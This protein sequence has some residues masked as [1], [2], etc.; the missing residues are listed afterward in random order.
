MNILGA[1]SHPISIILL[2]Y[3]SATHLVRCLDSLKHQTYQNYEIILI[4]NASKD[5]SLEIAKKY[6]G[7]LNLQ[8]IQQ[9]QNIGFAAANNL[10]AKMAQGEWLVLL[11]ADAFPEPDWLEKLLLAAEKYPE[12]SAFSSRQLSADQPEILDGAGDAYHIN[13][14]AWRRYR[15][16]P[17]LKYGQ[18]TCEVFTPC[19]AAAM[20][21]RDAFL[22]AGGFDEDYFA[23]YEDVDLGFRLRLLG[24]R[25]LYVSDA[26]VLHVGSSTF[27]KRS[28]FVSYHS[29]RNLIWTFIKNMPDELLWRYFAA[30]ILA[31]LI[32]LPVY[33]LRPQRA[34]IWQGKIDAIRNVK[35]ML[36]KRKEI[37]AHR[38]ARTEEID[39]ALEHG[40]LQPY[41]LR[42]KLRQAWKKHKQEQRTS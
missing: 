8:I 30:H 26:I 42:L 17:A 24:Y 7:Q 32:Y 29:Q 21:R 27:G 38:R 2:T 23:Y 6:Q 15:G 14:M 11:N 10:G 20:Y 16:Y 41:T 25:T 9:K 39:K 31:N 3:N 18:Q 22:E 36:E 12:Y 37:Q 13:G 19:A 40:L 5:K 35:P 28:D 34:A 1:Y 4:D 33:T